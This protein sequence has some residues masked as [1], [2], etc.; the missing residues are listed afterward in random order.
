MNPRSSLRAEG[1][2]PGRGVEADQAEGRGGAEEEGAF[3]EV[4]VDGEAGEEVGLGEGV[5]L[6]AEFLVAVVFAG[7]VAKAAAL[8]VEVG[9][10]GAELGDGGRGVADGLFGEGEVLRGEPLYGLTAGVAG[11]VG[12]D[13]EHGNGEVGCF[14]HE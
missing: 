8:A 1:G 9:E 7:R 11:F 10:H 14:N 2:L 4:A 13:G 3:D 12:V 5:E 6:V